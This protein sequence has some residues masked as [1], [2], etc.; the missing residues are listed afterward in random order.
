MKFFDQKNPTNNLCPR[1][2][3][4]TKHL[5][6]GRIGNPESMDPPKDQPL[7]HFVWSAGLP[8]LDDFQQF[9]IPKGSVHHPFDF[10]VGGFNPSEKY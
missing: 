10:L 1:K 7:S 3:K 4:P 9:P 2:S 8:G 5:P 6:N